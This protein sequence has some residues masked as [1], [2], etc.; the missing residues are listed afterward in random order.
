MTDKLDDLFGD[1]DPSGNWVEPFID[2]NQQ[3]RRSYDNFLDRLKQERGYDV[4]ERMKSSTHPIYIIKR[5]DTKY[6]LKF[7]WDH[8][9][10]IDGLKAEERMLGRL[11]GVPGIVEMIDSG[12][13]TVD[14]DGQ[15]CDEKEMP[16]FYIVKEYL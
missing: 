16:I 9:L 6:F 11:S 10:Y 7:N 14:A 3:T 4:V 12:E 13:F 8:C 5:G 2:D 15:W 1:P